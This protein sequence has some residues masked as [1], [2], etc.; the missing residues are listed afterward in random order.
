MLSLVW[1][2][3]AFGNL[4]LSVVAVEPM[5]TPRAFAPEPVI[6][7]RAIL[8]G[9]VFVRSTVPFSGARRRANFVFGPDSSQPLRNPP[10][11]F[12]CRSSLNVLPSLTCPTPAGVMSLPAA[13]VVAGDARGERALDNQGE[14][15]SEAPDRVLAR[16]DIALDRR[17]GEGAPAA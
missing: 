11:R 12:A 7:T 16:R 3:F 6:V 1:S 2:A 17:R 14:T 13:A 9:D 8:R 4:C 10:I 5:P 15:L